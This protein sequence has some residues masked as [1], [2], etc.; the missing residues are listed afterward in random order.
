MKFQVLLVFLLAGCATDTLNPVCPSECWPDDIAEDK[1]GVGACVSGNPVCDD[2][3]RLIDCEYDKEA[4][5]IGYTDKCDGVDNDC[6]GDIDDGYYPRT[7][8]S[9]WDSLGENPCPSKRGVC[10]SAEIECKNGGFTCT[11]P[12]T[13]EEEES[14]CDGLDNDCDYRVDELEARAL[15]FDDDFWKA[16]NGECKAG[17]EECVRGEWTCTGQ[18]LPS[19]ELCDQKDNDCNG[20]VDDTG[21]TL[22]SEYDIVFV[23]DTSGSMCEEISAVAGALDAY[24]E[25]FEGDSNFRFAIVIMS[26]DDDIDGDGFTDGLVVV[27]TGFTDLNT[28][29][30]RLLDVDCNGSAS[31][32]SLDS[33]EMVCN[34]ANPLQLSW[35]ENAIRLLFGFTD[36]EAQTYIDPPTTTY[37]CIDSCIESGTLPFMWEQSSDLAN[38]SNNANATSFTL[39]DDMQQIFDDLNSIIITLCGSG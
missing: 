27:D 20:I 34:H 31:E 14:T 13:Y 18:I 9:W 33:I 35:R 36:E 26:N 4:L 24:V 28:I 21:D 39:V 29:R 1:R 6:N 8:S 25:Q 23:I 5:G 11:L 12:N 19:A 3:N 22:S 30:N 10:A 15:C 32:A 16:T 7:S 17:I 38:I 2:N 37:D